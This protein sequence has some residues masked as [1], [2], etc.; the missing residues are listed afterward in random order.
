MYFFYSLLFVF[1]TSCSSLKKSDDSLFSKPITISTEDI[2]LFED[3][4][5]NL[6]EGNYSHVIPIFNKLAE[7]YRGHDLEWAALYNLASAYKE[8]NQCE[9]AETI[10]Q[11]IILKSGKIS[12]LK[13]R[14]YLSL[15]YVYEC[16]GQKEK[17]LIALKE[18]TR[19]INHLTQDIRLI[20]YPARLSIAYIR[21]NE[22]KRGLK[23]QK[24]VYQ[25]LEAVKKNFRISSAADENFSRYFYIIGRSHVRPDH[26]HLPT[27]L[28]MFPYHQA[29]LSQSFLLQAGNWSVMA[30]KEIGDLY[31]KMWDGLKKQ[32]DKKIYKEQVRKILNQ[33][34]NIVRTSKSKELEIIYLHLR[35]KTYFH[36]RQVEL[37]K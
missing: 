17:T 26:I 14:I 31:R 33:L 34:K 36:L 5:K 20:E 6:G 30:E 9:K 21:L 7:K 35:R 37:K 15:S 13:P 22:D 8:L 1:L 2:T 28:K 29:Y 19:Y 3:A 10:Y 11:N 23:I 24:E 4:F 16:L 27:F 18:G 32:K 12:H 25:N